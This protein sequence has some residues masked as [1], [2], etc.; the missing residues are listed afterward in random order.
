LLKTGRC[1]S[2]PPL[3]SPSV[4][5]IANLILLGADPLADIHNTSRISAVVLQ[6]H[7]VLPAH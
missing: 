1:S 4:G 7:I 5:K 6:G 2:A 3:H